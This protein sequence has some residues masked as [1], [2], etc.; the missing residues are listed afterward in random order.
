[1]LIQL[2]AVHKK[3][4]LCT[5]CH[6]HGGS[7]VKMK[8]DREVVA[9]TFLGVGGSTCHTRCRENDAMHEYQLCERGKLQHLC[10][11]SSVGEA[12]QLSSGRRVKSAISCSE[13][14]W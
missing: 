11:C 6:D 7:K 8:A 1:M 4:Y 3:Q 13:A 5:W 12:M 14:A 9:D 10:H 2:P